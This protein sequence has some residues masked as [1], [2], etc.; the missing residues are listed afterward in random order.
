[1]LGQLKE[2]LLNRQGSG[3][4]GWVA[5]AA[6][7]EPLLSKSGMDTREVRLAVAGMSLNPDSLRHD[8]MQ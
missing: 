6:C 3:D 8:P 4:P 5:A 2:R 1:M 7:A